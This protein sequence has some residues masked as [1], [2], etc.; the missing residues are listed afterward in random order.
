MKYWS[1]RIDLVLYTAYNFKLYITKN[2][3]GTLLFRGTPVKNTGG[4]RTPSI[5]K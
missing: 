1:Q 2:C 3:C 4:S 5:A